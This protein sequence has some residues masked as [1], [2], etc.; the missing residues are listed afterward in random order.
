[1]RTHTR[2]GEVQRKG[3]PSQKGTKTSYCSLTGDSEQERGEERLVRRGPQ[4][5]KR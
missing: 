5:R 3:G 2:L 1:M 4:G